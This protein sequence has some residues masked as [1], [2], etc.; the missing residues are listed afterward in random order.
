MVGGGGAF[1]LLRQLLLEAL[2]KGKNRD[3]VTTLQNVFF[4][5]LLFLPLWGRIAP[6]T[7]VRE[8]LETM[9]FPPVARRHRQSAVGRGEVVLRAKWVLILAF[10]LSPVGKILATQHQ[11]TRTTV[12]VKCVCVCGG[13]PEAVRKRLAALS[14]YGT[15][16]LYQQ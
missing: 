15:R 16:G 5:W 13:K 1:A 14:V 7:F 12:S 10:V 9:G 3:A 6:T 2:R 4:R 8:D 11:R